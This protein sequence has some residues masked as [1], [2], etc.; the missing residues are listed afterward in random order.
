ML[1]RC[2]NSSISEVPKAASAL[3]KVPTSYSSARIPGQIMQTGP[4]PFC[5]WLF[6]RLCKRFRALGLKVFKKIMSSIAIS[7]RSQTQDRCTPSAPCT[8]PSSHERVLCSTYWFSPSS[9]IW[10]PLPWKIERGW[11]MVKL[12][13]LSCST[14][15]VQWGYTTPEPV[16]LQHRQGNVAAT[17][18]ADLPTST[19]TAQALLHLTPLF[20]RECL[21]YHIWV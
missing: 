10:M 16:C 14:V 3:L 1:S 2:L 8:P 5:T 12:Q 11:G 13:V 17:L 21:L 15:P 7:T 9:D 18:V 6:S 4:C 20:P 19:F